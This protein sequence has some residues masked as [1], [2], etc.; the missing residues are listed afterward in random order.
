LTLA[1]EAASGHRPAR[2]P[3]RYAG[4][5]TG[6]IEKVILDSVAHRR[7]LL[8]HGTNST[9]AALMPTHRTPA[10]LLP[11][12]RLTAVV[13]LALL[14]G[15]FACPAIADVPA[16]APTKGLPAALGKVAPETV[17]DLRA[18][19]T[20][21][22]AVLDKVLPCTVGVRIGP[23]QGSGVIVSP[24]GYVLTAGHVSGQPDRAATIIFPDGRKVKGKTLGRNG[25]IDSGLIKITDEGTWPFADMGKSGTLKPG[26]WCIATGQP[27]G[28]REGRTPVVRLGRVLGRSDTVVRTDCALVGGDSGGPLFDIQGKVIGIHSRIGSDITANLHVPVDTYRATWERLAKGEA[29]GGRLA[30]GPEPYLGVERDPNAKDCKLLRIVPGSAAEKAE[31]K[32][33]DVVTRFGDTP[34]GSFED[35]VAQVA[36]CKPGDTVTLEVRRGDETI[37]VRVQLGRREG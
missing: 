34:I 13:L 2:Y 36:R 28:Y 37:T 21:V 15:A 1:D 17:A 8:H 26:D 16:S 35:L 30:Q 32:Q 3:T 14:A 11:R 10:A 27:G 23:G 20:Q 25:T 24:D 7:R 19:Q 29:W 18:I 31:L 12:Q 5:I 4:L 33:N 9:G 22:R 6:G